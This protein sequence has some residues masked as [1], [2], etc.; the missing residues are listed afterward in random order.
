MRYV[1]KPASG[2]DTGD[3]TTF[4]RKELIAE[5]DA[6]GRWAGEGGAPS[7]PCHTLAR[8]EAGLARLTQEENQLV[9]PLVDKDDRKDD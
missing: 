8:I 3:P 1:S 2:D 4:S 5:R 7:D 6:L 9:H